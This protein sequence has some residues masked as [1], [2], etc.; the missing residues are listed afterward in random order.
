MS[1]A[2]H[3][4]EPESPGRQAVHVPILTGA[5]MLDLA[6]RPYSR[7][8]GLGMSSGFANGIGDGVSNY[9][10]NFDRGRLA[11][12]VDTEEPFCWKCKLVGAKRKVENWVERGGEWACFVCC[13]G[14]EEGW[15]QGCAQGQG[16]RHVGLV[17]EG[18][19]GRRRRDVLGAVPGV[20]I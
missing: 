6:A 4:P 19:V 7:V 14:A 3:V 12:R 5:R 16:E 15:E 8:D 13:G 18:E 1:G 20:G 17:S 11:R 10:E 2:L 9:D